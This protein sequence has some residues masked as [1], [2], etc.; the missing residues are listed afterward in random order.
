[1]L[2]KMN[3]KAEM[4][5]GTLII[6]IAMVLVAAVAAGVIIQTATALQNKALLTGERATTQ[7]G[8]SIETILVFGEDGTN[9][10]LESFFINTKLSPGSDAL[11]FED[12]LLGIET[13]R[14]SL[15]SIYGE[16]VRMLN[17]STMDSEW[18]EFDPE[19]VD[20]TGDG[21][22]DYVRLYNSTHLQF[23]ISDDEAGYFTTHEEIEF[24]R[25]NETL[26]DASAAT[27]V[28][29]RTY[30]GEISEN[31]RKYGTYQIVG[32]STASDHFSE[33][34]L[35]IAGHG[36]S[37]DQGAYAVDYLL[38]GNNWQEGYL[39]RG[40][41]V[42]IALVAPHAM[43]EDQELDIRFIPKTGSPRTLQVVV[44][45]LVNAQRVYMFS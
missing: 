29:I 24:K 34:V 43:G 31:G 3:K 10:E 11:K 5:I 15:A 19:A 39:Q 42:Q 30:D 14:S 32:K 25:S 20:I 41:V 35:F 13:E 44:P 23:N 8:T 33:E 4:A 7:V 17:H 9:K 36:T 40:D 12:M 22:E 37:S 18:Y 45:D 28:E 1:M 2:K 27:P 21:N 16:R 38:R 26:A 6:F